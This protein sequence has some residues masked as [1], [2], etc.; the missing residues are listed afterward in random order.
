MRARALQR[1]GVKACV[2]PPEL[3]TVLSAVGLRG[4]GGTGSIAQSTGWVSKA[5]SEQPR[6]GSSHR[7]YAAL[8]II[9]FPT[10]FAPYARVITPRVLALQTAKQLAAEVALRAGWAL[11]SECTVTSCGARGRVKLPRKHHGLAQGLGTRGGENVGKRATPESRR[12]CE[13]LQAL[14][15]FKSVLNNRQKES[16]HLCDWLQNHP[17]G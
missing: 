13:V 5:C 16:W 14:I 12:P 3:S 2:V 9:S 15:C 7:I 10:S 8:S 4:E 17:C 1:S 11:C 6:D